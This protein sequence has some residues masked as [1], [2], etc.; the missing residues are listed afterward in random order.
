MLTIY[1]ALGFQFDVTKYFDR[2]YFHIKVINFSL[3]WA[4]VKKASASRNNYTAPH[5]PWVTVG[6]K[7]LHIYMLN[8]DLKSADIN[9]ITDELFRYVVL[10]CIQVHLWFKY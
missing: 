6:T 4:V 2:V 5:F 10:S 8:V 7:W 1:T 3:H 9:I